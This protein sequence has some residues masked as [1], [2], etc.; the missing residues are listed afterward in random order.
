MPH[1]TSSRSISPALASSIMASAIRMA[2]SIFSLQDFKLRSFDRLSKSYFKLYAMGIAPRSARLGEGA[3]PRIIGDSK[4]AL[5]DG[6]PAAGCLQFLRGDT[7]P[8]FQ[9]SGECG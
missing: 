6:E 9:K 5:P 3:S 7:S 2:F 4:A 8:V 1:P